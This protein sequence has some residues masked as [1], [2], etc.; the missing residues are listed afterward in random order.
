MQSACDHKQGDDIACPN[1]G[2][3][4]WFKRRHFRGRWQKQPGAQNSHHQYDERATQREP[5]A[6]Q[7]APETQQVSVAKKTRDSSESAHRGDK[8][9]RSA[10][11]TQGHILSSLICLNRRHSNPHLDIQVAL[12][13]IVET[14]NRPSVAL[15]RATC[16]LVS[17]PGFQL[18]LVV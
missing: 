5:N 10:A 16:A 7:P 2:D 17:L 12:T 4:A 11:W 15:C 13:Q 6:F 3:P 14:I 18:W 8:P 1:P 9:I